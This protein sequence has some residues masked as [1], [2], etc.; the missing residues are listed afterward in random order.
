MQL[1]RYAYS[2]FQ[3]FVMV[4]QLSLNDC[5]RNKTWGES[6]LVRVVPKCFISLT[7]EQFAN[8]YTYLF[9][10]SPVKQIQI[11]CLMAAI[12]SYSIAFSCR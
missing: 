3:A 12:N 11:I 7:P 6:R 4:S 8:D 9:I 5:E 1:C 10:F 2:V